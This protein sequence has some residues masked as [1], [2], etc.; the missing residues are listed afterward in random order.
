MNWQSSLFLILKM[1]ED[2]QEEKGGGIGSLS[3]ESEWWGFFN[4]IPWA[5]P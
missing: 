1:Y 2:F 3:Y 4:L 5:S